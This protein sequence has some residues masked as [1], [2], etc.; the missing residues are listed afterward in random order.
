MKGKRIKYSAKELAWLKANRSLV[1]GDYVSGFRAKFRKDVS[2]SNLHSLRKR[3]GWKTGRSGR[4]EKGI[5]PA[6]KGKT[7]APGT[8]GRHPNAR[9]TQF[10]KG[11]VP[12][13]WRGAGHE[14][15]DSKSGYVV[16]IVAER[17][18]WTG[19]KTRPV[20]KHRWLWEKANGPIPDGYV[21][22]CLDGDKTNCD[23]SN[24]VAIP[25]ALLP[26]LA[27]G[28]WGRVPFDTAPAELKPALMAI[29]K[30]EHRVRETEK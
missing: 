3:K 22:K 26:R 25:R 28:R 7:C 6:N 16:M 14:R 30:L 4:F 12:H 24:W 13:T 18:P 15:I 29:A 21:L 17:N 27:G 9:K 11:Q 10:K 8:G 5:V 1:I 19:T 23:P 2:A 20:F